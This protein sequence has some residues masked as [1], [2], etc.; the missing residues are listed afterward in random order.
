MKA[1][2]GSAA[3]LSTLLANAAP[4][5]D[6]KGRDVYTNYPYNGPDVPIAD[7]VD[8]TINGNGKGFIRLVEPPAVKPASKKPKNNVNVVSTGYI[9]GGI[10]IHY[11]TPFGLGKA[12][13]VH[14]GTKKDDL[15]YTAHG[16]TSTY[17]PV[18]HPELIYGTWVS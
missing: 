2:V 18:T 9:P 7:W 10:N 8:P 15:C 1:A 6:V 4:T 17:V 16:E 5:K 13:A 11:Q 3:L 14:Y 12:P